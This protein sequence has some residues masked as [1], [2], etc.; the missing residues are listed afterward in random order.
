MGKHAAIA[1]NPSGIENRAKVLLRLGMHFDADYKLFV[2]PVRDGA[3]RTV[4]VEFVKK[5][6]D[7]AFFS[8]YY[9]LRKEVRGDGQEDAGT[10][11]P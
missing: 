6:T 4:T 8:V 3:P 10:T 7:D 1:D 2:L 5:A 11:K 9:A